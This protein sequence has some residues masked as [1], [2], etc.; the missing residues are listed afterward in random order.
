MSNPPGDNAAE[1]PPA[2]R[3]GAD[4]G[5]RPFRPRVEDHAPPL[6]DVAALL[7]VA[8][9]EERVA[10]LEH[11]IERARGEQPPIER[12]VAALLILRDLTQIGWLVRADGEGI[13]LRP[14]DAGEA[15]PTKD[16]VRRQSALWANGPTGSPP[17]PAVRR[18]D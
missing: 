13:V 2:L 9:E 11:E 3:T 4:N 17:G 7:G 15:G 14:H 10:A 5:W 16:A 6:R 8:D 12:Y 18:G 1:P